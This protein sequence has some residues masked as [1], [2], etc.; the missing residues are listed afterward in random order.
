M[1]NCVHKSPQRYSEAGVVNNDDQEK[2]SSFSTSKSGVFGTSGFIGHIIWPLSGRPDHDKLNSGYFNMMSFYILFKFTWNMTEYVTFCEYFPARP[3]RLFFLYS[4]VRDIDRT[5]DSD[6]TCGYPSEHLLLPV[7]Q[8]NLKL[9][10]NFYS[11]LLW[12]GSSLQEE[13]LSVCQSVCLSVI[14]FSFFEYSMIWWFRPCKPFIFWKLIMLATS[15]TLF[16]SST[17]KYG[18]MDLYCH[19][20]N[21]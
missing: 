11:L 9:Q 1:T 14:T 5:L 21:Q 7:F 19:I 8:Q 18:H 12:K 17:N 2:S 6:Q 13:I 4:P 16:W 3:F 10:Y 15:T 20:L